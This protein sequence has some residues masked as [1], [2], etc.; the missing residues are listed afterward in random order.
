MPPVFTLHDAWGP[1]FCRE[2][3]EA[4]DQQAEEFARCHEPRARRLPVLS[5]TVELGIEVLADAGSRQG[6]PLLVL[7]TS[8]VTAAL[9]GRTF[10]LLTEYRWTPALGRRADRRGHGSGQCANR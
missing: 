1:A 9:V 6:G 8:L 7:L 2:V 5:G 10:G 3:R 4:M